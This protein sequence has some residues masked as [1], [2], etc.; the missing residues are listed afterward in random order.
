MYKCNM[1]VIECQVGLLFAVLHFFSPHIDFS[2]HL[3][4]DKCTMG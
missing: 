4:Y 3:C 1:Y 2:V